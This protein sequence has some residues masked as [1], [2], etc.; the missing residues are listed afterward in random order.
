MQLR[1]KSLLFRC[2]CML[3]AVGL[4]ASGSVAVTADS[5]AAVTKAYE[6]TGKWL[7]QPDEVV[8]G[9]DVLGTEWKLDINDDRPAP[10]ND[11]VANNVLTIEL[12][13]AQFTDLPSTCLTESPD[14]E[15]NEVTP[16]SSLSDDKRTLECNL[17]TRT[18][19]TAELS[20]AG[21]LAD[22]PAG[23]EVGA[24]GSFRGHTVELPR[25]P[26][27]NTFAMDAKF[28]DGH[29]L[30]STG[31]PTNQQF[32][33]F[34]FSLSH[35]RQT[36]AGPDSVTVDLEVK[37]VGN[38]R[39]PEVELRGEGCVPND[40]VQSGHPYSGPG[41]PADQTTDFPD[42]TIEKTGTATFKLTLS[43]LDYSG[44]EP[45]LD[46][47]EQP[48]AE[49]MRVI[50]AG[51]LLM[52]ANYA[53][54]GG[55]IQLEASA[56]T[57][58][59]IDGQTAEDDP[60]NNANS[61]PVIRGLWSGGWV[62][63]A[64][65]PEAYPGSP[66][67][68]TSRAPAGA[69][70]MSV[71]GTR[72][73]YL[74]GQRTDN[75]ICKTIDTDVASF[76]RARVAIKGDAK[77][78][79]YYDDSYEGDI[80]YYTGE[81]VDPDSGDPVD[82]NWFQCGGVTDPSDPAAGNQPG[83]STE[84]P[85]DLSD[86]KAVK[87]RLPKDFG[88]EVTTPDNRVYLVLEQQI[89]PDVPI[90][91]EVWTWTRTL[92][93]GSY[94]WAW[95]TPRTNEVYHRTDNPNHTPSYGTGT[96]D[97]RYAYA[98]PGRDVLRVVGSEPLVD[99]EVEKKEYGPGQEVDYHVSFGLESNLADPA[100]DSV[101]VTDTLP[102]GMSYVPGSAPTEPEVTGTPE[103]GQ[104]LTWTVTDVMP[105][106]ERQTLEFKAQLPD[107][108]EPG[109]VHVNN[110]TAQ[111]QGIKREDS[112]QFIVPNSGFTTLLKKTEDE[113]VELEDGTAQNSWHLT[114]ESHDPNVSA[115]TDVID[116][117][118]YLGDE[119]GTSF[120]GA[121]KL[122]EVKAP[123]GATVYYSTSDPATLNEDPGHD[124]NGGFGQPSGIWSTE[125]TED[126]TAVRVIG[127][128]LSYGQKQTTTITV[129]VEGAANDDTYVNTAVG[130]ATSTEMR[131]RT[132]DDFTVFSDEEPTEEPTTPP[133][134]EPTTP[135]TDEPTTPPTDEPTTPPT[136]EPTTPPTD[137]PTTP[138][139]DEPTTPP[140]DE[141]TTPPT[142]EPTTPPTEEPTT[143]PAPT[144]EP[145]AKPDPTQPP[146][147][148]DDDDSRL[149]RTG[150]QLLSAIGLATGLV[151]LGTLMLLWQRRRNPNS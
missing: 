82:P 10:S 78:N 149:P 72:V 45:T 70:V 137:E 98:A 141:P 92:E 95:G 89:K 63:G 74:R 68:D 33:S 119:R 37:H 41:H 25:I 107:D 62:V 30:S 73:P 99:K 65:R 97:A 55:K 57:Y 58:T 76:E 77:P 147:G 49:R 26:I 21:V 17:G 115:Q 128:A 14:A 18:E 151:G 1:L 22:G 109:S 106:A 34:P 44:T 131:M 148:D 135:P 144:D 126:A 43:G 116:I 94:N 129:E 53:T 8:S 112:A 120:S 20:F 88:Q 121:L 64:Q 2:I 38:P 84:L 52:R 35:A 118:P 150:A 138:P 3:A 75:W 11:P 16:L 91:T 134:D 111:S 105:N 51:E 28:D 102:K 146:R 125:F 31:D 130:R 40:R 48:L 67:T 39:N 59:A 122:S 24:L 145:S 60:A 117:L 86:V 83:W 9:L 103:E 29:P 46:S 90:G 61:V 13:N 27:T 79:L 36:P 104:T 123:D 127:G 6:F 80:W 15:G 133:T 142:D 136:D 96:P 108:A 110:V 42:C 19:G 132:S 143:P 56:P 113:T 81:F 69:T 124:S 71:G 66:W 5:A 32:Y 4:L 12:E 50:A 140:T 7:D 47:N 23:S 114:L 54:S 93:E 87:V 100:P 85:A 101:V 139:T